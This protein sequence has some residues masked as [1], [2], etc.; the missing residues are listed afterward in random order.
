[1][2][3]LSNW[4]ASSSENS[5]SDEWYERQYGS[6]GPTQSPAIKNVLRSQEKAAR[7]PK[8][9]R[10]DSDSP[11]PAA[12]PPKRTSMAPLQT[13]GMPLQDF[14]RLSPMSAQPMSRHSSSHS[15]QTM[16]PPT[17]YDMQ[18]ANL[19]SYQPQ[20]TQS[21]GQTHNSSPMRPV[22]S[23]PHQR[24][25]TEG[26]VRRMMQPANQSTDPFPFTSDNLYNFGPVGPASQP[27]A[28]DQ[29]SQA[30]EG[31][32]QPA[33]HPRP[34][35]APDADADFDQIR[36]AL[37]DQSDAIP[38]GQDDMDIMNQCL[39]ELG[40]GTNIL[41]S[42][43][44]TSN[45]PHTPSQLVPLPVIAVNND[46]DEAGSQVTSRPD[47]LAEEVRSL[48]H[49]HGTKNEHGH[50]LLSS[51]SLES[52]LESI[53]NRSSHASASNMG[54]SQVSISGSA[55]SRTGKT[56]HFCSKCHKSCLRQSDLKK[57][58]KRHSRPY[59][60]VVDDCY[61]SFGS[62]ND[63]KRHE[64]N[65]HSEQ[66]ECYRCDGSHQS[67]DGRRCFQVFYNGRDNYKKHLDRCLTQDPH[68]V[69][70]IANAC[71]LPA[72]NQGRFW[73]GFCN[74]IVDHEIYGPEASS[75]RLSHIDSHFSQGRGAHD[76]VELGGNGL[77]KRKV[78]IRHNEARNQHI[79]ARASVHGHQREDGDSQGSS[80]AT[81]SDIHE[82]NERANATQSSQVQLQQPILQ[83]QRSNN[84]NYQQMVQ[85]QMYQHQMAQQMQRA[86]S[87]SQGTQLAADFRDPPQRR[88]NEHG[89]RLARHAT[90]CNCDFG[91]WALDLGKQ[92]TECD[93]HLCQSCRVR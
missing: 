85:Q 55:S 4:A 1:M 62:K 22:I 6:G 38:P 90:C 70:R 48:L 25:G 26:Q 61:K 30:P 79:Q 13:Q 10:R 43:P 81:S 82:D 74:K 11:T 2:S 46:S 37:I 14:T 87:H 88:R 47:L 73:C 76:W 29:R 36:M 12:P 65:M 21:Y 91:D 58:M 45:G 86:R 24:R 18:G 63:L 66:K 17:L 89:Q 39:A 52:I 28:F 15:H 3:V 9:R 72:N 93:H 53:A 23:I 32:P 64:T 8:R 27:P 77:T 51:R 50:L 83:R 5:R 19:A 75:Q 78:E 60:C 33:L 41:Q 34:H 68:L 54:R 69:E 57:H 35:T 49:Q 67:E 42:S 31:T 92:C 56:N 80:S 59:G 7:T 71:R 16:Q 44:S 84:S 20:W 40:S